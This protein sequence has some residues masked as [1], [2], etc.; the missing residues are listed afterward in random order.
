MTAQSTHR[1]PVKTIVIFDGSCDFCTAIAQLLQRLDWRR[2]LTC[3]PFQI[4]GLPE[5]Y[6]LSSQ[7]CEESVWTIL[8]DGRRYR[9]AQAISLILDQLI[10]VPLLQRLYRLPGLAPLEEGLYRWVA[11]H[12]QYL[13]GVTPFCQRPGSPCDP[14]AH[15]TT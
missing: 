15:R 10:G 1:H 2:R 5:R 12:R 3:L 6:G 11:N 9:G 8:P 14:P 4:G 7:Q 13:P